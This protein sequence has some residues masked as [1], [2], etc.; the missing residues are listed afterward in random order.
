MKE[1]AAEQEHWLDRQLSAGAGHPI[2]CI[3][4]IPWFTDTVDEP[5]GIFNIPYDTRIRLLEKLYNA[6][7]EYSVNGELTS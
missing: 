4:H 5:E 6:G 3:S 7:K 2:V 1:L